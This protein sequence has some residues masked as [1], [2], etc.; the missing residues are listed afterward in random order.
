MCSFVKRI[1]VTV[2]MVFLFALSVNAYT[3]VLRSGRV[4]EIPSEFTVTA[5][6]LTYEVAP[7]IQVTLQ[8]STIDIAATEKINN[9]QPGS[10]L[11]RIEAASASTAEP[12][13]EIPTERAMRSITNRDLEQVMQLRRESEAAY[14]KR[15]KELGL[16]SLE[17]SREQ[18]AIQAESLREFLAQ[19]QS[20]EREM[21]AYWR[22]RAS[23]LR[24]ERLAVEAEIE[25]LRARLNEVPAF[26][27]TGSFTVVSSI[28]PFGSVGRSA[29]SPSIRSH[30]GGQFAP[31]HVN[32]NIFVAPRGAVGPVRGNIGPVRGNVGPRR[33]AIFTGQRGLARGHRP[34]GFPNVLAFPNTTVF[35]SPFQPYD[36]SYERTVLVT[37]LNELLAVKAGLDARWRALEDEARRAGA[38]PGWLRE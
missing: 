15:L 38:Q 24:T 17:E 14:E 10:F 33:G 11:K 32:R 20:E 8:M 16:P 5:K 4:V 21:E 35:S 9:E 26:P 28:L 7:G 29:V 36:F 3:V 31:R 37:R 13:P 23:S 19:K 27:A 2:A 34:I 12:A 1:S 25:F 22:A 30:R 18:A 6:T